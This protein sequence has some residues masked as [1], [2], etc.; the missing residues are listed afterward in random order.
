MEPVEFGIL[1]SMEVSRGGQLVDLGG[2]RQKAVLAL[3]V[4]DANRVVSSDRLVDRLWGETPP[5]RAMATLRAYISNLRRAIDSRPPALVV[6]KPPGYVLQVEDRSIDARTFEHLAE[7]GRRALDAGE[8]DRASQLLARALALWRG[9]ALADFVFEAFVQVEA[10]RLEEL[11][12]TAWENQMEAALALGRHGTAAADLERLVT[13]HPLRERLHAQ[14]MLALYRSGRQADALAAYRRLGTTLASELG[15]APSGELRRLEA[16]ILAQDPDLDWRPPRAHRVV[17]A[18]RPPGGD[19]LVGRTA[20]QAELEAALD[21]AVTGSGRVVLVAGEPGIGK[22]RL[23]EEVAARAVARGLDV[24]WAGGYEGAA[25]PGLWLWVQVVRPIL[26]Y[27]KPEALREALGDGAPEVAHILPEVRRLLPDANAPYADAETARFRLAN[28]LSRLLV[29][30]ADRRPLV[31]VLD[32][33]Q[34]A[35]RASLELLGFLAAHLRTARLLVLGA[36]RDVDVTPDHPLSDV[37]GLLAREPEVSRLKLGGL[38][39]SEIADLLARVIGTAPDPA[40]A[41]SVHRRTA[42]NPF[43][44]AEVVRV[45]TGNAGSP[46]TSLGADAVPPRVRDVIRRRLR[47]LPAVTQDLLVAAAVVGREFALD[48]PGRLAELDEETALKAAEAALAAG[49]LAERP[50][51]VGTFRFSHD[52]VRE[53]LYQELSRLRRARLHRRVAEVLE[54]LPAPDEVRLVEIAY[55]YFMGV[56]AGATDRAFASAIRAAEGAVGRL[57]YDQAEDQLRRARHVAIRLP[58][59]PERKRAELEAQMRLARLLMTTRGYAFEEVGVACDRARE[60][61]RQVGGT[62]ELVPTLWSLVT[63]YIVQTDFHAAR[64]VTA[65]LLELAEKTDRPAVRVAAHQAV[66]VLH[67]HTGQPRRARDHLERAATM[68]EALDDPLLVETMPHDPEVVCLVFLA[69]AQ[70]LVGEE[71]TA[72][73]LSAHALGISRERADPFT[74][75]LALFFDAWLGVFD[76]DVAFARR[77]ADEAAGLCAGR[78]FRLFGAMA[79]MLRGWAVAR[80]G[81]TE[82]GA[83]QIREGLAAMEATGARMLRHFFVAVLADALMAGRRLDG[84]SVAVDTGLAEVRASGDRFWEPELHR[85]KGEVLIAQDRLPEAEAALKTAV[86]VA[87]RQE[88]ATLERRAAESLTRLRY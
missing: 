7:E 80:E 63:F 58:P 15:L 40:V 53:A 57:A 39:P 81:N 64:Q 30:H 85:L 86:A 21:D 54:E 87:R 31:I 42:G 82:L 4:L 36:Y 79:G 68:R 34:W 27:W 11:R 72:R 38:A 19:R 2:H 14:L 20:E 61:S 48:V 71:N 69:W 8:P 10:A 28:A 75:A 29:A 78:G 46:S 22:T 84:A 77:R 44:V 56:P 9:P 73:K 55:H 1:G 6:T 17:V 24:V 45:L 49:V 50:E 26:P 60:L 23:V 13:A 67:L 59:G 52:L 74:V 25:P 16:A 65:Q 51:E 83:A 47:R 76:D 62:S 18:P 66:G 12:L 33:L 41:A 35:D 32:D 37:L 70:W 88:A 3:L 5:P 43:F